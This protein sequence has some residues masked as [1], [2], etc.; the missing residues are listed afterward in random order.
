MRSANEHDVTCV[1]LECG[2]DVKLSTLNE[3][4]KGYTHRCEGVTND[5]LYASKLGVTRIDAI[6]RW[7]KA[8][9][10]ERL[11]AKEASHRMSEARKERGR[12]QYFNGRKVQ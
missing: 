8:I 5:G 10:W 12:P 4:F 7:Q 1:R 3:P 2:S 9:Q 11:R 6:A